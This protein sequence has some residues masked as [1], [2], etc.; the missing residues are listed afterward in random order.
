MSPSRRSRSRSQGGRSRGLVLVVATIVLAALLGP[1]IGG[2]TAAFT[3]VTL[4]RGS[5]VG[6]AGD[7]TGLLG[8]D[9]ATSVS[10]GESSR[11]VTVTNQLDRTTTVAVSVD[12]GEGSLSNAGGTLAP[13]D[14]LVTSVT[15]PCDTTASTLPVTI[16]AEAGSQF[17]AAA[18]RETAIETAN[19]GP[20]SP[21][22]YVPGSATTGTFN[23]PGGGPAGSL[24][25]EVDN[26]ASTAKTITGFELSEAGSATAL[27]F[28]GPPSVNVE[29]GKD[30]LYVDATGGATASE[31]AAE[32]S[33][34]TPRFEIGTGTTY[35]LDRTVTLDAGE[36]AKLSL[37]Q[38]VSNGGPDEFAAG[39][40]VELTLSFEDGSQTTISFTV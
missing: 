31:G 11:L 5:T 8:L 16:E 21:I 19:C 39:D 24:A 37:Y 14:S 33:K 27:S 2:P 1:V 25:F 18:S 15:V 23:G 3:S 22:G 38:F 35:A 40:R 17:T 26:T 6:V 28:D 10:A 13:G 9:V 32:A 4:D 20:T 29:Q 30:E 12:S 7:D 34:A 36:R